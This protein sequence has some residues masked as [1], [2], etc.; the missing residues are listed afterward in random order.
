MMKSRVNSPATSSKAA[1]KEAVSFKV[2]NAFTNFVNCYRN[3]DD[4]AS[5]MV[6]VYSA[7]FQYMF[8]A[9][10]FKQG[11]CHHDTSSAWGQAKA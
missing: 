11:S 9:E 1:F 2:R 6:S 7:N 5:G 3:P 8:A 10:S 4:M